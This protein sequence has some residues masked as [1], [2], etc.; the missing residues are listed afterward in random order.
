[1]FRN[2]LNGDEARKKSVPVRQQYATS[3]FLCCCFF[4]YFL[5]IC[6]HHTDCIHVLNFKAEILQYLTNISVSCAAVNKSFSNRVTSKEISILNKVVWFGFY[7]IALKVPKT[8]EC[9]YQRSVARWGLCAAAEYQ[10]T[11]TSVCCC[12]VSS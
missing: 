12:S 11:Y 9:T 8:P 3:V 2:V 7:I 4:T 5:L 10:N 6:L 1:M